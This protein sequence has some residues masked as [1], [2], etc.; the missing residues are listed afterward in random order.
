[1]FVPRPTE[2]GVAQTTDLHPDQAW[3]LVASDF[4]DLAER[5][6]L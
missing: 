6:Q 1:A 2:H 5:L 3:D 4:I